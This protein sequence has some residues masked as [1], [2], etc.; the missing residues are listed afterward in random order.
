MRRTIL[1][2]GTSVSYTVRQS[3]R[4][5][6]VSITVSPSGDVSVTLPTRLSEKHSESF[7][8][9]KSKWV[10]KQLTAL[11]GQDIRL[12][13]KHTKKEEHLY[14]EY[15]RL[16][17]AHVLSKYKK[18]YPFSYTDVRIK[19]HTSQWGSCSS[20]RILNF[21][22][23][24]IFLPTEL[25]EYVVVHELCHLKEMNHSKRYW[26]LVA[27]TIPDHKK[28]RKWIRDNHHVLEI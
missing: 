8:R 14:K 21:N 10:L 19:T 23:K 16:Y 12:I 24:L 26:A 11:E 25:S 18:V 27:E 20:K 1:L 3:T 4:A 9:E 28:W 7:L 5:K 6:R 13:P 2:E 17:V 22:Y 15:A